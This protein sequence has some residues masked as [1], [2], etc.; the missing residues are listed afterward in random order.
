MTSLQLLE[1]GR[2]VVHV[3]TTS[4]VTVGGDFEV[5]SVMGTDSVTVDIDEREVVSGGG[6]RVDCWLCLVVAVGSQCARN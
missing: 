3:M 4:S 2:D 5:A 6:A 1:P